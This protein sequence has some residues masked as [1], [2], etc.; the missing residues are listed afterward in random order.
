MRITGVGRMAGQASGFLFVGE[1]VRR[2]EV[3]FLYVLIALASAVASEPPPPPSIVGV[4]HLESPPRI[5]DFEGMEPHGAALKLKQVSPFI[6]RDPSDGKPASQRT[7][8]YMGYDAARL[9][10]VWVCWDN[11]VRHLRAHVTTREN[12]FNDDYVE[13]TIDTFHDARHAFVFDSNPFGVQA[14]GLWTEASTSS[15]YS[16]DTVWDTTSQITE[17]GYIVMMSIPFRSLRFN[18]I[19]G[20]DW[21]ITLMRYYARNDETDFWPR[22]SSTISGVLKQEATVSGI[23]NVRPGRN[24]QFNPYGYLSSFRTI[25]QRDPSQPFFSTR[26]AWAKVGLDSKFVFHDSLVLDTTINPDFAQIESDQPQ[27][28]VNQR[29]EVFFPEKRPFFLENSNFIEPPSPGVYRTS[30]LVF[31]RRIVDPSFGTRLTGK[32][33]PW[34]LGFL[35][36]DD[37]APGKS[38]PDNDPLSGTRAYIGIGHVSHDIGK[39]NTIGAIYTDREYEGEYNR[40]GGLDASFVLNK[41]FTWNYRGVVSSTFTKDEGANFGQ[42]HETKID[43]NG[44]R[45]AYETFY[46]DI[47]PGFRTQLGF[48]PRTDIRALSHY[49]HFYFHPEKKRIVFHGPEVN[50]VDMWDH[51]G[52]A[53]QQVYSGD[54]VFD[55]HPNLIFAPIVSVETDVLRPVVDFPGLPSNQKYVQDAGG[56][57]FRGSPLR[58]FSFNTRYIRDGTVVVVPPKGQLPFVG[59]ETAIT[60][61]ITINPTRRLQIDNTYILDRVLNGAV[62]HAVFNNHI[63]RSKWNYQFTREFALRFIT[64]WNGLLANQQY[65]SLQTTKNLNFDVLFTYLVHP[66]TAIYVGY[67]SDLGNVNPGLCAR[68]AGASMCDPNGTGLLRTPN[69]FINDGRLFFIKISYLFRP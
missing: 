25:D 51:N 43:G 68:P 59:D 2:F 9:Y 57:V 37:R 16:F 13:A 12:V 46:Q 3:L 69:G 55:V 40:V 62:H 49:W 28:T 19:T 26:T 8:A 45:F 44:R 1:F 5:S 36:T 11:D 14:D 34:N 50:V 7:E 48:V 10:I 58:W 35:V 53:V 56:F 4:P 22:V 32:S 6:Q 29:F 27:N 63:I 24:M 54:Y 31:T 23:E 61:S 42:N 67:N 39:Q 65:S 41:N 17:Q 64:E 66:G 30:T 60:Q 18:P 52:V 21:G 15:D 33:G 38:V 20:H 47:S